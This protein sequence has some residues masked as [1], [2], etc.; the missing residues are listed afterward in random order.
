MANEQVKKIKPRRTR[1]RLPPVT[2][3]NGARKSLPTKRKSTSGDAANEYDDYIF[4]GL[5]LP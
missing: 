2:K 1:N 5:T 3:G 4:Y